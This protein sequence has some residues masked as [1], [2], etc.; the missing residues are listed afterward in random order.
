VAKIG[1]E[2]VSTAALEEGLN[3]IKP[4]TKESF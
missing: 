4:E 3:I 1:R 2:K